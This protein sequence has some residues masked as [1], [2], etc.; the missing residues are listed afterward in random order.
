[1]ETR[2]GDHVDGELPQVRV[3]RSGELRGCARN[4]KRKQ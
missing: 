2:E 1:V 3:Q 4:D